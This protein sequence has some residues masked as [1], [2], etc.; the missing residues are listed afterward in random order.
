MQCVAERDGLG[1]WHVPSHHLHTKELRPDNL[2]T[3]FVILKEPCPL[4]GILAGLVRICIIGDEDAI[5]DVIRI[6]DE[7][8]MVKV[9]PRSINVLK[10]KH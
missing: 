7:D 3:G 10:G 1:H 2:H 6:G 5:G 4:M 9:L 8:A